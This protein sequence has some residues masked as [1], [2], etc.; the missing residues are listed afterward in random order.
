MSSKPATKASKDK[1]LRVLLLGKTGSGKSSVVNTILGLDL[2]D[3][4][5]CK[6]G[7]YFDRVTKQCELKTGKYKDFEVKVLDT[8]GLGFTE[9]TDK[10][11]KNELLEGIKEISPGPHVIIWVSKFDKI[12]EEDVKMLKALKEGFKNAHGHII[13]VYTGEED[14]KAGDAKAVKAPSKLEDS[15][16]VQVFDN[17]AKDAAFRKQAEKLLQ[18]VIEMKEKNKE[19]DKEYYSSDLFKKAIETFFNELDRK[20]PPADKG[21]AENIVDFLLKITLDAADGTLTRVSFIK[22]VKDLI[23]DLERKLKKTE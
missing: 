1:E 2:N 8:P 9:Q 14:K 4:N 19:K 12:V 15:A 3:P 7:A 13:F 10:D 16:K 20:E 23:T 22:S 6:T 11:V 5:R 21:P 18:T 17:N